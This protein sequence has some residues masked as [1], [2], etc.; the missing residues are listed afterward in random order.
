LQIRDG[1]FHLTYCTNIHAADGWEAVHANL[2]RY[3]TALKARFAPSAPFGLGLRLSAREARELLT[4]ERLR[5]FRSFLDAEGL[6]VALINGFPY[7][8]FHGTPVKANVYA[9]DWRDEAR[10]EYTLDLVRILAALVPEG[11]DGGV[12]TAPLSYKAW[13]ADDS[14][15]AW[16]AVTANVVR[17][18]E[19]MIRLRSETGILIHLDIEPEPDCVLENTSESLAFFEKWLIPLGTTALRASLGV[20]ESEA[21]SL[22]LDHV[23]LCFDCC[24]FAVEYEDPADALARF[25]ASGI[26]IGRVQ[27]SS[28][29]QVE[30]PAEA[31]EAAALS[32]QLRPF[33]DATYLHQVV[34]PEKGTDAL[35]HYPDLGVAL[36]DTTG[37]V[38]S[39]WRIHFHVPLFAESYGSFGS[40]QDYVRRV[41]ELA[42]NTRFTRHLE[43]ETYTWDVL[44]DHLKTGDIVEYVTREL[45]WVKGQLV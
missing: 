37:M 21:R 23:R 41:L 4:G 28:A 3:A 19:A 9:P 27:L 24:H 11:L 1:A 5:E 25:A 17:V 29:L 26:K 10:V 15:E 22:L 20:G 14:R 30:F 39:E 43:I 40:T 42:T 34:E 45:D 44:P 18:A 35:R 8:P 16:Q 2:R 32:E 7:G 33:A 6:Y 12:S 13:M 38:S 36:R 31:D